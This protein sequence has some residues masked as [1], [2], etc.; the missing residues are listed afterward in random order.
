MG[1]CRELEFEPEAKPA[2]SIVAALL[3]SHAGAMT[4][5]GMHPLMAERLARKLVDELLLRIG[6]G[7]RYLP[8]S[9]GSSREAASQ[10]HQ[11]I[12]EMV[13]ARVPFALVIRS[14]G[15]SKA[16]LYRIIRRKG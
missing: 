14:F 13:R 16:H 10:R 5:A 7:K 2:Q 1:A 12:R 3:E 15:I 4:A 8:K 11:E 6:G 9:C